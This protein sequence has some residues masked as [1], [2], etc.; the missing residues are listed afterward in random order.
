MSNQNGWSASEEYIRE[1]IKRLVDN[2]IELENRLQKIQ[3]ELA[4][5]KVKVAFWAVLSTLITGA[6]VGAIFKYVLK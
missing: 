4:I 3:I 1:T 2:D 6:A 5:I